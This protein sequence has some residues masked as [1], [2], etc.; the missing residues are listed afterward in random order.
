MQRQAEYT[1]ES[2]KSKGSFK[3]NY[4]NIVKH[5]GIIGIIRN[6]CFDHSREVEIMALVQ[7]EFK[8][9]TLRRTATYSMHLN[10]LT[11][12]LSSEAE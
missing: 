7:M 10:N 6:D 9:E 2:M 8:S 11:I 12:K 3:N 1:T 4:L 5:E